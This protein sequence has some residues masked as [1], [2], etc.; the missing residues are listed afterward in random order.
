MPDRLN[1]SFVQRVPAQRCCS[2]LIRSSMNEKS[3]HGLSS[4][5]L[6]DF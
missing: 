5:W 3:H 4:W 6:F 2:L 1:G